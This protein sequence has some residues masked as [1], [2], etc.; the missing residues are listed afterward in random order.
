MKQQQGRAPML[1]IEMRFMFETVEIGLL[2][3]TN[4]VEGWHRVFIIP[5]VMHTQ[6][7]TS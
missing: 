7:I 5:W 2:R 1:S 6:L 3:T 4:T